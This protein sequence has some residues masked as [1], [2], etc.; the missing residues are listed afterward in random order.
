[1][2]HGA[3]QWDEDV[4]ELIAATNRDQGMYDLYN[5]LLD[6]WEEAGGG[7]FNGYQSVWHPDPW[8]AFGILEYR[9]QP[10]EDAPKYR[11]LV[12]RLAQSV[13]PEPPVTEPQG[14]RIVAPALSS[15]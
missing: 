10:T 4:Q 7:L 3:A 11:A 2:V 8:G 9:G 13:A 15:D 12:H 6:M 14:F 1:M 5:E